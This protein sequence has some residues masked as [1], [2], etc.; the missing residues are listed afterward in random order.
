[1]CAQL[2]FDICKEVRVRL[3][4]EHWSEHV[5]KSV[6]KSHETKVNILRN[7]HV[8]TDRTIPNTESGIA[9]RDNEGACTWCDSLI[10]GMAL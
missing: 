8:Q 2:H 4:S 5:P 9:I 10:A 3:D 1:V 6:E 7:Q